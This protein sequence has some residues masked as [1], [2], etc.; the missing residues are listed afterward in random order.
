MKRTKLK[1]LSSLGKLQKMCD[2][3]MQIKGK[4]LYP[5][6][7]VSGK[8][9][10]VMHHY[11]PKSVSSALR[12]FWL[13]LIPLTNAEHCRL[14]QSPDPSIE[15]AIYQRMGGDKW[16]NKLLLEKKKVLKINRAYYEAK[17]EELLTLK[18]KEKL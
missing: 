17:L 5:K 4:I 8:P 12:Y 16:F 3:E 15:V 6:S 9:T 10:E 13:N 18:L 7:V 2:R 1:K 14:H 11:I